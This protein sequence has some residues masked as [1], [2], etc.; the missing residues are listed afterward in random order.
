[1]IKTFDN[2]F[3]ITEDKIFKFSEFV[4]SDVVSLSKSILLKLLNSKL[5]K[6]I[7]DHSK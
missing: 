3:D 5:T 2:F 7:C 1:M 4:D 6:G